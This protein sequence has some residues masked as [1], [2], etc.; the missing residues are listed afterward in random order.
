MNILA[1][2]AG[3][4]M[5]ASPLPSWT[6]AP[7]RHVMA[8]AAPVAAGNAGPRPARPASPDGRTGAGT[9]ARRRARPRDPPRRS[10]VGGTAPRRSPEPDQFPEFL[11]VMR[12]KRT[13][14]GPKRT[15]AFL[16]N[17]EGARRARA[18]WLPATNTGRRAQ[19]HARENER[20]SKPARGVDRGHHHLHGTA[21]AA[22]APG[23]PRGARQRENKRGSKP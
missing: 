14:V 1:T 23:P 19:H 11:L 18:G 3:F 6:S 12:E 20:V 13:G 2:P 5:N 15:V 4:M 9:I 7:S 8:V 16:A 17:F 22:P 10:T 21:D